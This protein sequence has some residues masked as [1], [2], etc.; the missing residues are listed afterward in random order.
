MAIPANGRFAVLTIRKHFEQ[1]KADEP[2][3]VIT[4]Q[5]VA[6]TY[7]D[8]KGLRFHGQ[9][10]I[11]QDGMQIGSY[12]IAAD[13]SGAVQ[14]FKDVDAFIKSV[15]KIAPASAG[16]YTVQVVV[17]TLLDKKPAT[18]LVKAATAEKQTLAAKK[19]KVQASIAEHDAQLALMVGWETGNSLQQAKKL[20]TQTMKQSLVDLVSSIDAEVARLTALGG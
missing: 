14:K 16:Q 7:G 18:D 19:T 17:G 12:L 4:V 2:A 11:K 9:I 20:E 6:L 1:A 3:A 8:D 15:A 5:P 13:T 10:N